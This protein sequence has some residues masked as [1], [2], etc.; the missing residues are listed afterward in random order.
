MER[1]TAYKGQVFTIAFARLKNG[2]SPGAEF[3][4]ALSILE[5]AGF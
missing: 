3:Y 4:D 2:R 5:S 1:V